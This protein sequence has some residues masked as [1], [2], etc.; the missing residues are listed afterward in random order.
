M[1]LGANGEIELIRYIFTAF[2]LASDT[3]SAAERFIPPP[4]PRIVEGTPIALEREVLGEDQIIHIPRSAPA[5]FRQLMGDY[6]VGLDCSGAHPFKAQLSPR[7]SPFGSVNEELIFLSLPEG[8]DLNCI[9]MILD[10]STHPWKRLF[11]GPI[12]SIPKISD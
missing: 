7:T 10:R 5:E 2:L 1:Q 4:A 8:Q 11:H 6:V 3:T 9:L 12:G